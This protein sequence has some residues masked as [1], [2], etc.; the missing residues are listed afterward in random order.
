M[1]YLVESIDSMLCQTYT[2]LE[3]I[4]INDG[5]TDDTGKVLDAYACK[6]SRIVVIHNEKNI[7]LIQS[8]NNG[9][10]LAKGD[11]IARMD[12]DDVSLPERIETELKYMEDNPDADVVG[13]GLRIINEK[14]KIINSPIIRQHST[15][16]NF[17]ASFFYVP[18]GHSELLFRS[19]VLKNNMYLHEK[20]ALHTED[21][22]LWSRLLRKGYHL[23]N[24]D[25]RLHLFRKNPTS[26]SWKY[27]DI[28]N[29]NFVE[30]AI[31]HWELYSGTSVEKDTMFV[32]V[33]RFSSK[34][35]AQ[36]LKKGYH[37]IK[38]V[39]LYYL[40]KEKNSL[41]KADKKEIYIVYKTHLFDVLTQSLKKAQF[42][43]KLLAFWYLIVNAD[44]LFYPKVWKYILSKF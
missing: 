19:N 30:C 3:I 40:N 31:R 25:T 9:I 17:F 38:H 11:F 32:V 23:R 18:L 41:S 5:S 15:K 33:N 24:I 6:D 36:T 43:T 12:S 39:R 27:S 7:K 10:A 21:Y 14:S 8:L 44:M 35:K 1:P 42:D 37:Q 20:F 13:C 26:I 28:Q 16:A 22:E 29:A 4:C 2:N 34:L